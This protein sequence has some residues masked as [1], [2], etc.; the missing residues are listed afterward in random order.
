MAKRQTKQTPD[1]P[2][3]PEENSGIET[4]GTETP[5]PEPPQE[6]RV[7]A[8]PFHMPSVGGLD[9]DLLYK[10]FYAMVHGHTHGRT[11]TPAVIAIGKIFGA[12]TREEEQ[13]VWQEIKT[14]ILKGQANES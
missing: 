14:S 2:E 3:V 11:G 10:F 13:A 8:G 7:P 1:E 9:R 12:K 5:A 4:P 6:N